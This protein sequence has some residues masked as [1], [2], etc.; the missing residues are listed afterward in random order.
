MK[1]IEKRL[2]SNLR[3]V[4]WALLTIFDQVKMALS[5]VPSTDILCKIIAENIVSGFIILKNRQVF[6]RSLHE[7][8]FFLFLGI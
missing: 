5:T 4:S 6:N 8:D 7:V 3:S 2:I 1:N